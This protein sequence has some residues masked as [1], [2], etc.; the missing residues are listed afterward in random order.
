MLVVVERSATSWQLRKRTHHAVRGRASSSGCTLSHRVQLLLGSEV[1]TCLNALQ[2]TSTYW[3]YERCR[4]MIHHNRHHTRLK[5][6]I[7]AGTDLDRSSVPL[8]PDDLSDKL[9]VAHSHEFVHSSAGHA[10]GDNHC[11]GVESKPR[12][13]RMRHTSSAAR[14]GEETYLVHTPNATEGSG[15]N[16]KSALSKAGTARRTTTTLRH[17]G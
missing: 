11:E 6:D 1:R 13:K 3:Y 2:C 15:Q 4:H 5:C 12:H 17:K 8:E 7:I 9:L 14:H 16:S 10:L